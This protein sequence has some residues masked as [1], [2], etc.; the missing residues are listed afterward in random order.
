MGGKNMAKL[1]KKKEIKKETSTESVSKQDVCTTKIKVCAS[2]TC[3][4]PINRAGLCRECAN[5]LGL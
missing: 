2:A 1:K 3:K 5:N 4:R